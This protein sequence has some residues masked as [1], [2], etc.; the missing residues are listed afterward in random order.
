MNYSYW[1]SNIPGI[2]IRSRNRMLRTAGSAEE[3]YRMPEK[4]LLLLPGLTEKQVKAVLESRKRDYETPFGRLAEQGI[5][6]LSREEPEFPEKLKQIPD[7]PYSLYVKGALPEPAGKAVAVVG[8][9]RC[10]AY[11]SAVAQ[12]LGKRLAECHAAVI[13]GMAQGIDGESHWG[14]LK[15]GG[16]T[17]A[18]LGCGV[19]VCYPRCQAKLYDNILNGGGIISEYP[20]GTKPL[21]QLFPARNR[22][23][24]GL[25][26]VVVVVEAKSRSGS[27]ITADYA[28]E[29]GKDIYAVPGRLYD[30]LSA[31]CNALIRQGAGMISDVED[32]LTELELCMDFGGKQKNLRKL[33]LAKD[34]S[35]VYSCLSLQPKGIE[36]LLEE[37]GL[38]LPQTAGIL[39]GMV[40]K[41][42]ITET[43]K[44]Y[45]IKRIE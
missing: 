44:N 27:L 26:D 7:A 33:S 14:A 31:G 10:S 1:L 21:P 24:S 34:E 3:L 43:V 32:F 18:V 22:I 23:I 15:G 17:Y 37:T 28:L 29:Q 16:R 12:K 11:G 39:A 30:P 19:D 25:S 36:E 20:P 42:F 4:Q 6:F 9:R 41:G 45:Y 8:A 13:S 35:L 40:Q 5:A 2:G 38:G